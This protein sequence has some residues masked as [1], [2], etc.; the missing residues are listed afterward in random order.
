MVGK[1]LITQGT[2]PF[3]Q[4]VAKLLSAQ[5]VVWFGAADEIPDVLLRM[6]SYLKIPRADAQAFAHEILKICLDHEIEILIPLGEHELYPMAEARQL[7]SEYGIAIWVP[8]V[9]QLAELPV[10]GN[11]PRQ[12]PLMV[13]CHG[14]VVVGAHGGE[15]YGALS[16]VFTQSD[17]GGE[18]ALC[19]VA[20]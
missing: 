3:A 12:F 20:D 1:V 8:G 13:L 5:R 11:P 17:S 7:F 6:D 16:G 14:T 4:R 19:C 2:R 10:I 15:R 18:L 9:A